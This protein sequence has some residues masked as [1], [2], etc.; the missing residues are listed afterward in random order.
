M[1]FQRTLATLGLAATLTGGALAASTDLRIGLPS[2]PQSLDLTGAGDIAAIR[3]M[4]GNV[5]ETL[6]RF[7]DQGN[8][9]PWLAERWE[10]APD[11]L[12][13]TLTLRPDIRFH[14]GTS[15]EADD[16]A[17]SLNRQL[18]TLP[19]FSAITGVS[20]IDPRTLRI[21]L[22]R[23][24]AGLLS[25]LASPAA[26]IVAPESADNN[27]TEPIGTGPFALFDWFRGDRMILERNETYWGEHP[28]II[29]ASLVVYAHEAAGVAALQRGDVD[30]LAHVADPAVLATL[31]GVPG[32]FVTGTSAWNAGIEGVPVEMAEDWLDLRVLRWAE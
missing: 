16:A 7:D 32:L 15:F 5:F 19:A 3:V 24:D 6:A 8:P 28:K 11:G 22:S 1:F 21:V 14:D 25:A 12:S 18:G 13:L 23:P 17:F 29:K 2:E 30:G 4:Y 27:G 26:V 31:Q 20:V 9:Q 10:L